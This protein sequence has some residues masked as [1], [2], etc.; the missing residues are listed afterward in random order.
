VKIDCFECHST[1]PDIDTAKLLLG[2]YPED[3][4]LKEL[5]DYLDG[6]TE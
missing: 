3:A 4:E 2:K 1:K 5:V 6:M